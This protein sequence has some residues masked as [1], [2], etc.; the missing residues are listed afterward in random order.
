MATA[1]RITPDQAP[2]VARET[3][4][5]EDSTYFWNGLFRITPSG[6]LDFSDGGTAEKICCAAISCFRIFGRGRHHLNLVIVTVIVPIIVIVF[7]LDLR[8]KYPYRAIS[9]T[10]KLSDS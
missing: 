8:A 4:S 5:S 10:Y 2:R 1:A 9:P 7:A 3:T 6:I